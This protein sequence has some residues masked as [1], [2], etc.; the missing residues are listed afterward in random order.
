M[1]LPKRQWGQEMPVPQDS[2]ASQVCQK[3]RE[4]KRRKKRR[5]CF[6]SFWKGGHELLVS[7]SQMN[8]LEE[9]RNVHKRQSKY[10]MV[11][12]GIREVQVSWN[13]YKVW[14]ADEQKGF[15]NSKTWCPTTGSTG[16]SRN[17]SSSGCQNPPISH[18]SYTRYFSFWLMKVF[19]IQL[20]P[21]LCN[22][23]YCG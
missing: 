16:W 4:K 11:T 22:P 6:Q 14:W 9:V 2:F 8:S 15:W 17:L 5:G 23:M 10:K 13:R 21:T 18:F 12:S 7:P 3:V 19:V 20:C 1:S